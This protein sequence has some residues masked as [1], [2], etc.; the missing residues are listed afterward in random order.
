MPKAE[1]KPGVQNIDALIGNRIRTR[2]MALKMDQETLGCAVGLTPQKINEH[3]TGATRIDAF[4]LSAMAEALNVPIL[5]FF[6]D[7]QTVRNRECT[8]PE[9][10]DDPV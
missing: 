2:R 1:P 9:L 7:L 10:Q 4:H 3:E 5:F 6:E 8:H